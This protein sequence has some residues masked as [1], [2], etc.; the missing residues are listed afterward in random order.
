MVFDDDVND[1]LEAA[2][3]TST[4]E[5]DEPLDRNYSIDDFT[6]HTRYQAQEDLEE[7]D[8]EAQR[9]FEALKS[10]EFDL[11]LDTSYLGGDFWRSRNRHGDGFFAYPER[12]GAAA[13]P[14]QVLARRAGPCRVE[15]DP[16]VEE[17][18][19]VALMIVR[20]R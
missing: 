16:Q 1:Y 3:S 13:Q 6:N 12:Y 7:F 10:D 11:M 20:E 19:E 4:D 14:L 15:F 18:G 5:Y 9:V 8:L 17:E 2:L